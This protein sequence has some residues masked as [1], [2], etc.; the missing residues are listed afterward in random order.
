M[1]NSQI[2]V[3]IL[4]WNGKKD[5]LECL[6]SLK[7]VTTP[8]HVI[9][10]DNGSSDDSLPT[11]RSAYPEATLLTTGK[12]LGYAEGNNVGIRF[13]LAQNADFILILNNDTLVAPSILKSFLT[14]YARYPFSI[15]SG[16][17][18]L[19]SNP[20]MLDHLGGKWNPQ[21]GE[22][23]LIG[24]RATKF[25]KA[26]FSLDYGCGCA[27]FSSAEVFRSVGEFDARFFL[28]WEEA[29]WCFRAKR[30]GIQTL[31]CPDATLLHKVSASFNGRKPYADYFWWR[32]RLLW[33]E[34]NC[35]KKNQLKLIFSVIVP[36]TWRLTRHG[37]L[38]S[39]KAFFAK[40]FRTKKH[41]VIEQKKRRNLA[42]LI[43]I[44][45]YCFRRFY[46][47]PKHLR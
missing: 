41:P 39:F 21:K 15:L 18:Y 34:K 30:Q 47:A 14:A 45:D 8:H 31:S 36:S 43:G 35:S 33:I 7:Q 24:L 17:P 2:F 32:N 6:C 28:F 4:N 38:I 13:A 16:R 44:K 42:A 22:F 26:V 3:V 11:L 12:N 40:I 46:N 25:K 20:N 29:D 19:S 9:V 5:T 10:V 37:L 1:K 27:L 23:D